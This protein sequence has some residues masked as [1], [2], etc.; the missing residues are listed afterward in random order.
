LLHLPSEWGDLTFTAEDVEVDQWRWANDGFAVNNVS[1]F[2]DGVEAS[3]SGR[4]NFPQLEDPNA[5]LMTYEGQARLSSPYWSRLAQYF[6]EDTVHFELPE[7]DVAVRGSMEH[8]DGYSRIHASRV[9]TNG[10]NFRDLRAD[11][12]LRNQWLDVQNASAEGHGG[13][14]EVDDAYLNMYTVEYGGRG[15]FEGLNPYSI[16]RD[17]DLN[18]PWL[19]G[20]A[21]GSV[22]VH[23]A[24]PFDGEPATDGVLGARDFG[25]RDYAEVTATS[26]WVLRRHNRQLFPASKVVLHRGA[27][28]RADMNTVMVP[29]AR[30]D[31]DDDQMLVENLRFNYNNFT[32]KRG[33]D[34][35]PLRISAFLENIA[36]WTEMYGLHGVEGPVI[37]QMSLAGPIASPT[38]S[39]DLRNRDAPLELAGTEVAAEDF[40]L[41]FLLDEGRLDIDRASLTTPVG[42]ATASGWI[43]L[44]ESQPGLALPE[45][46]DSTFAVRREQP[47][48]LSF[49]A[50]N[51][52][53]EALADLADVDTRV[54]GVGSA[55]GH[56]TG[57]LQRPTVSLES[58][59]IE[60]RVYGQDF[61]RAHLEGG[62]SDDRWGLDE[63]DLDAGA[64]GRLRATGNLGV[65]GDYDFEMDATD[66]DLSRMAWLEDLPGA[67]RPGGHGQVSLHGEGSL[68][69]PGIGGQ[70]QLEELRV[71]D[72]D[73]GDAALVV[74]AVDQT[75]YV[76]G[77]I[78]PL[79]TVRL[80]I[81]LDGSSP[82]YARFGME[83]LDLTRVFDE[84]GRDS[85]ISRALATGMVEVFV[86]K[87]LSRYQVLTNLT[88]LEI[89][90]LD[91]TIDNRGPIVAGFNN[92]EVLQ[93][94]RATV[95]TD[96]RYVSLKGAMIP[97]P[98]LVDLDVAGQLDLSLLET[99]RSAFPDAFPSSLVESRG[100]LDVDASMRGS[101]EEFLADGHLDFDSAEFGV[102]G[103]ADPVAIEQGRVHLNRDRV[104]VDDDEPIRGTALGGFFNLAGQVG[105]AGGYA[106]RADLRAWSHN[107]NYRVPDAAQ[108]SFDTDLRLEAVDLFRP[109]T[110][111]LSG[112]FDVLDGIFYRDISLFEEQLTGRV[113]GA[114]DRQTER[115]EAGLFDEMPELGEVDLDLAL[116]ARDGF[117]IRNR[118]DR[119]DLDLQ[120]RLD[121]RLQNT[122]VDPNLTGDIDVT[123]GVVGFQGEEFEVR[124]GT[125]RYS[126]E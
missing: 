45:D 33:A 97:D 125:V 8:I 36:P 42:S 77:A 44:L 124:S 96:D 87:D 43:D 3:A 66:L 61:E 13:R 14:V 11:I 90:A 52:D 16:L 100:L 25:A 17:F 5:S 50:D 55:S 48:E 82:Y 94:Q 112:S 2:S 46:D 40:H 7:L 21:S 9:E 121:L 31:L 91:R 93:I 15:H 80:E 19:D 76:T 34:G 39:F 108:L 89:D 113:L 70:A 107:M 105:L 123:S 64:A 104:E 69:E 115:Y 78:L 12:A 73:L 83:Q 37:G 26:D 38:A 49:T 56:L 116:R 119:L 92:G 32:F 81:P 47:A 6:L 65:E 109:D 22:E 84:L 120:L 118:V 60:G 103:L 4:M 1:F 29:S 88:D 24:Y 106:G 28:A 62:F 67:A 101:S 35:R 59:V 85:I 10:F 102:R 99:A 79:S 41:R 122:L 68:D 74:N 53:L 98:W 18:Y 110:W 86:E 95:G 27:S 58:D 114:F 71:G 117:A 57:S 126:G 23:G 30:L 51:L 20:S 63:L 111:S 54:S 72:R 75:V